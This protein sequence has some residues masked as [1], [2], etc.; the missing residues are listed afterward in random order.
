[1]FTS[2]GHQSSLLQPS[3][4]WSSLRGWHRG[5][6][7]ILQVDLQP[8]SSSIKRAYNDLV[9]RFQE[10]DVRKWCVICSGVLLLH[11]ILYIRLWPCCKAQIAYMY[12]TVC[13]V[14]TI[15]HVVTKA[16]DVLM[17][18]CWLDI[19][20]FIWDFPL[21]GLCDETKDECPWHIKWLHTLIETRYCK[22][23]Y[24]VRRTIS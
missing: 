4:Y 1:M 18:A 20:A 15:L 13:K 5:T 12:Y 24:S 22:D 19:V 3:P 7:T 14:N 8:H 21:F 11:K 17:N 9:E 23:C 2:R 16:V 10:L 6:V